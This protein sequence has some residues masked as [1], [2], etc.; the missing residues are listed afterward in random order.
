MPA[1]RVHRRIVWQKEI[2]GLIGKIENGQKFFLNFF[3][4][5]KS[6]S[7]TQYEKPEIK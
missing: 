3:I 1:R 7:K 6:L 4:A 5:R 2:G